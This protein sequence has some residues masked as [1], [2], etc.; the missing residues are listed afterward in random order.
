MSATSES[1][2]PEELERRWLAEVLNMHDNTGR[3]EAERA[4]DEL[5]EILEASPDYIGIAD[6]DGAIR[7]SNRVVR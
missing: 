1:E 7:Y 3:R 6:P 2:L 4:R 5:I